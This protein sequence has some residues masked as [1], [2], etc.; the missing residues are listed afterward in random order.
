MWAE[1]EYV[2]SDVKSMAT[3]LMTHIIR[4]RQNFALFQ[5]HDGVTGTAKDHVVR[6]YAERLH[7]SLEGLQGV[8]SYATHYLLTPSKTFYKP[9]MDEILFDLDEDFGE[10]LPKQFVIQMEH[11]DEASMVVIFNSHARKRWEHRVT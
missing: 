6:D 1:M 5:H 9:K 8:M 10:G 7:D 4:A 2:G 3:G 11:L